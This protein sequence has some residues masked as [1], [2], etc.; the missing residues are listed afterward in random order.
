MNAVDAI[1]I[2]L[3]LTALANRAMES[4]VRVQQLVAQAQAEGR[5]LSHA[6]IAEIQDR[7]IGAVDRWN[8]GA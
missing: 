4:A 5:D 6:E 8:D 2:V 3:A 7:R 1:N